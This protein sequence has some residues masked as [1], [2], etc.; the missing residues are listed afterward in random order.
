[1]C[2]YNHTRALVLT[3]EVS[4]AGRYNKKAGFID[5][6][7]VCYMYSTWTSQTKHKTQKQCIFTNFH[8]NYIRSVDKPI[9]IIVSTTQV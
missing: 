3:I 1:M 8:T 4:K 9:K 2:K 6:S 5:L 7:S